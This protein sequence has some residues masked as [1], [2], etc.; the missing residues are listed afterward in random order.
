MKFAYLDESGD[1]SQSDV[2]VMAAIMIDG[3][4]LRKY[5]VE[6]DA[7]LADFLAKHPKAPS[8]LKTKA[9]I[10][11]NDKWSQVDPDDRKN[12]IAELIDLATSCSRIFAFALSFGEFDKAVKSAASDYPIGKSYWLASAMF[13]SALIQKKNQ[14]EKKNK[15]LTVLVCDDNKKEMPKLSA[16]LHE[17]NP[18][19]DPLYQGVKT[20][21]GKQE[22]VARTEADRFDQIVNTGFAIQS[23]H[24]SLVQVADAVSYVYR[25]HLELKSE[26]EG[27][28]GE[29]E[30]F[31]GLVNKL[32][33]KRENIGRCP[34]KEAVK[35]F[36]SICHPEWKA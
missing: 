28:E 7:K 29:K 35:V 9:A 25:R 30:Y 4:K 20:K 5:T 6:F 21:K 26:A 1:Q 14:K 12:F 10:Q 17:A 31:A 2:F 18:W 33:A 15:G 16:A 8:E 23:E 36:S 27:W 3:V 13:V 32:E 19:F 11:G 34:D 24:A 22:F